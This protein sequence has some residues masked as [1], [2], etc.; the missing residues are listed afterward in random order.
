MDGVLTSF[1]NMRG[2][3]RGRLREQRLQAVYCTGIY[4]FSEG[5]NAWHSVP[6]GWYYENFSLDL[7]VARRS[8]ERRRAQGSYW[9]LYT[10]PALCLASTQDALVVSHIFKSTPLSSVAIDNISGRDLLALGDFFVGFPGRTYVHVATNEIPQPQKGPF[11]QYTSR[12]EGVNRF[13]LWERSTRQPYRPHSV[14]SLA[15]GIAT[16]FGAEFRVPDE[17]VKAPA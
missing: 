4:F 8:I 11:R 13:L 1:K 6:A 2:R 9:R 3:N 5:R 17:L 12:A 7:W 16:Q 10:I 15:K 14:T